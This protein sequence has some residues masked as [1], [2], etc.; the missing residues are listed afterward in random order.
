MDIDVDFRHHESKVPLIN[1]YTGLSVAQIIGAYA[2]L[3][4]SAKL[5]DGVK[6]VFDMVFRAIFPGAKHVLCLRQ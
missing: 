4:C 3:E 2:Y 1:K 5:N 6:D